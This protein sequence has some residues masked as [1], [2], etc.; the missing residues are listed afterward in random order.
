MKRRLLAFA[1]LSFTGIAFAEDPE[2]IETPDYKVAA[3]DG[4]FEVRAYPAMKV[5]RTAMKPEQGGRNVGFWQLFNYIQGGNVSAKKIAMTAP[6]L[7][8]GKRNDGAM[9][10][11]LP[12]EVA[13]DGAP[14]PSAEAVEVVEIPGGDYAALRFENSMSQEAADA[15]KASLEKWIQSS[16]RQIAE[17]AEAFFAYYDPP[18][19]PEEKKRNEV[20][21]RLAPAA[22]AAADEKAE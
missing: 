10:F 6:V 16:G 2:S 19:T 20:L 22:A 4:E 11:V 8:E 18:W 13:S 7:V 17:G 15:A 1:L 9:S 3:Q 21:I 5:V 12:K 14:K